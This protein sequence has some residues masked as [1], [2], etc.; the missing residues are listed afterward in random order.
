MYIHTHGGKGGGM[1]EKGG[2]KTQM[3]K[4]TGKF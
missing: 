1:E 3:I 4:Q 2:G